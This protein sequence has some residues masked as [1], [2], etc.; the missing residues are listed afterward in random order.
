MISCD[1][2]PSPFS[3]HCAVVLKVPIPEPLPRGPGRWFFNTSFLKESAFVASV[4]RFWRMWQG[5]KAS[6]SSIH[7][8][9]ELGKDKIKGLAIHFSAQKSKDQQTSYDLLLRLS[10]HLKE[11]IDAGR[12]S[13]LP[14]YENVLNQIAEANRST[15]EGAR[16]RARVRWAEEGKSSSAYF[17]CL[18]R[19][20]GTEG[21]ISA[22]SSA[23][24][25]IISSLDG[26]CVSWVSF[27]NRL[28]S[29]SSV[30][31]GVQGELLA[32]L[33]SFLLSVV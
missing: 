22:M 3:D 33:T 12:V 8:W 10:R 30:D 15:A 2:F 16:V 25:S 1:M 20:R 4:T 29:A 13:L 11:Q 31:L 23:D 6:F 32:N 9:W 19:K 18:E 24:G 27:Y 7:R 28:F 21:W 14:V 17:F 26:I 5:Q